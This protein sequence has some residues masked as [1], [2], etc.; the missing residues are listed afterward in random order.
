MSFSIVIYNVSSA[1]YNRV[2]RMEKLRLLGQWKPQ[3]NFLITLN[4]TGRFQKNPISP[5]NPQILEEA[6]ERLFWILIII[7]AGIFIFSA[8]AAYFLAGRTLQPIQEMMEDQNRFIT[9]ASHELRTPLTSLKSEI[10]VGLRDKGLNLSDAKKLLESNLEEVLKLQ[11]LSDH[12]IKLGKYEVGHDL[13]VSKISIKNIALEAIRRVLV[14]SKNKGIKITNNTKHTYILGDAQKLIELFVVFLDNAIKYSDPQTEIHLSSED[15]G[16]TVLIKIVDQGVGIDPKEVKSIFN[17][18]Y[19]LKKKSFDI[20]TGRNGINNRADKSR[21]TQNVG[22]YG[23][24]LSI[25]QKIVERHHGAITVESR[26]G[27]GTTFCIK[28]PKKL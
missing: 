12:L 1:E 8:V 22:G 14:Q 19:Q 17:R 25:A 24:G 13:E 5:P 15:E 27:E 11:Y 7:N 20:S 10:E 18:F 4:E 23:L 16:S 21:K 28:L 9:D 26:V 6:S 3:R 2:L